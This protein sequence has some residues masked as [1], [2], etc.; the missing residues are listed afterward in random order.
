M[1]PAEV[2]GP[3]NNGEKTGEGPLYGAVPLPDLTKLET[4]TAR[5]AFCLLLQAGNRHARR[6]GTHHAY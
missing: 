6:I 4:W 1:S 5:L 3:F 2:Q